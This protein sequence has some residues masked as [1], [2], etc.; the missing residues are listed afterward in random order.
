[1]E[2]QLLK[3]SARFS[4][5]LVSLVLVACGGSTPPA[6]PSPTQATVAAKSCT[7]S[8]VG[9]I[10]KPSPEAVKAMREESLRR[11]G[12]DPTNPIYGTPEDP[13]EQFGIWMEGNFAFETDANCKVV[14]GGTNIFYTY[15]YAIEGTVKADRSFDMVFTGSGVI[16]EFVGQINPNGSISGQLKHP[17]PDDF[18]YGLLNGTFNPNGKI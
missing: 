5:L 15:P 3:I 17:A 2:F 11:R 4:P 10:D 13:S 9:T 16:G 7:G 8:Y 18:I 12:I 14:K 6:E 1:M